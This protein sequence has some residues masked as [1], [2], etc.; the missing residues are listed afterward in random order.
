MVDVET[1][2]SVAEILPILRDGDE[3]QLRE[4][5][6][7]FPRSRDEL[8]EIITAL[9]AREHDYGTCV[10][11]ISLSAQ[12]TF[13]YLSSELGCTGFQ[14]SC[15]DMDFLK[16]TRSME[17]GFRIVNYA[18]LLYPQYREKFEELSYDKL[19]TENADRLRKAAQELLAQKDSA[20]S[21]VRK[22]WEW[23]SQLEPQAVEA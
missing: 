7:P 21:E 8:N 10:Y 17:H 16:R 18:D 5:K 4:V 15:A 11:A 13:N 23:L 19:I 3:K 1:P 6:I 9:S 2:K 14:A 20:H 12:A 22:H